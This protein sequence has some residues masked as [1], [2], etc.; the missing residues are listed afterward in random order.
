MKLKLGLI[1]AMALATVTPASAEHAFDPE[2]GRDG[3]KSIHAE[4]TQPK[5]G[6]LIVQSESATISFGGPTGIVG[7]GAMVSTTGKIT[8]KVAHGCVAHMTIKVFKGADQI[9]SNDFETTCDEQ[10]TTDSVNIGLDGGEYKFEISGL[11][12]NHK[13]LVP[14]SAGHYVGDPP[15]G[16]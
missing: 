9:H 1:A 12:C 4:F 13:P 5:D 6:A 2:C 3:N 15:L 11:G 7:A 16:I 8:V 10:T 14:S